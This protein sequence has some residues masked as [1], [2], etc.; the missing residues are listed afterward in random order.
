MKSNLRIL[1]AGLALIV[2][3]N[4]VALMGVAYNRSG[5]PEVVLE[6]TERE[7]L[8]PFEY[9]FRAENSGIALNL[10]WRMEPLFDYE[11][12]YHGRGSRVPWFDKAKLLELGFDAD[13]PLTSDEVLR[14]V[15]KS[16]PREAY[17]VLEFD[18][19]AYQAAL[20]SSRAELAE[21]EQ[22]LLG[23]PGKKEFEKRVEA[24]RKRL[25]AEEQ[26]NSRLFVIDAGLDPVA[27]RSRYDDRTKYLIL[28]GQVAMGVGGNKGAYFLEG[29]I[30]GL[31]IEAINV[32]V[33]YHALLQPFNALDRRDEAYKGPRYM[34]RVAFGKR[35]EP[36]IIE[37]HGLQ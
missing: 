8:L 14:G 13:R 26:L 12:A 36:W 34:A 4:A 6:L 30:R 5:E 27:L 22:L 21:E 9:G 32:P 17:L 24:A 25:H 37:L 31:D 3:T 2:V 23:N 15:S 35:L 29:H 19:Q 28:R 7:L 20:A 16:L 1:L 11:G 18:G 10:I 33:E